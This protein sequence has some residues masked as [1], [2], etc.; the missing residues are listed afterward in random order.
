M[1]NL[2]RERAKEHF[3]TVLLTLLS[4]VQAIA[5]ELL[6]AHISESSYLYERS[7]VAF[8]GWLQIATTLLAVVLIW[9][10]YASNAMRFRWVPSTADSI[11]PF[12]VGIFEFWMMSS[13]GTNSIGMWLVAAGAC[14][15]SMTWISHLTMRMAR[16]DADNTEFFKDVGRATLVD[17]APQLSFVVLMIALALLSSSFTSLEFLQQAGIVVVAVFFVVQFASASYYWSIAVEPS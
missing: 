9:V 3:P 16:L 8:W 17:F 2:V 7:T 11:Y 5:L 10:V 12:A 1:S 15:G 4:I 14:V 6:W 13:L